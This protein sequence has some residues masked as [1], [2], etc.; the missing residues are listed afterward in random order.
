MVPIWIKSLID[1]LVD[2]FKKKEGLDL[3]QDT[4]AMTRIREASEKAKIELSTVM[5]TD[6]NLPFIAH[7]SSTGAKNLELRIT[8][9]KLDELIG[10]I[11]EKCKPSITKALED[12]KLSN[13]DISKIVMVG[14]PTRI[15]LVKKIC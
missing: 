15:P 1:Y 3:S 8:R 5:E 4:T 11:V 9:A 6:I 10:P 14:G 12:A 2:E 13:A 7:D